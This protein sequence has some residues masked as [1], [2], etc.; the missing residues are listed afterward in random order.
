VGSLDVGD[1]SNKEQIVNNDMEHMIKNLVTI[2]V[3]SITRLDYLVDAQ[4]NEQLLKNKCQI[5]SSYICG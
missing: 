1:N 5:C 2:D 4:K 3:H